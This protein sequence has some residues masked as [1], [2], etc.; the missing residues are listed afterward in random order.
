MS[1]AKRTFIAIMALVV[2]LLV[3]CYFFGRVGAPSLAAGQTREQ[4]IAAYF[5]EGYTYKLV[6]CFLY[7]VHGVS[8]SLRQLKRSLKRLGLHRRPQRGTA[9]IVEQ[10]ARSLIMYALI[11]FIY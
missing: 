7:F 11:L 6:I 9:A 10:R 3:L 8:I 4:L 1:A 2:Y 5:S